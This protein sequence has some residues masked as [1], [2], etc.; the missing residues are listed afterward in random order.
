MLHSLVRH[1]ESEF[2]SD[3]I[4]RRLLLARFRVRGW[5][6]NRFAQNHPPEEPFFF[7]PLHV[8]DDSQ[9][10]VRN[11]HFFD[12]YWIIEYLSRLMPHGYKLAVKMHP[13]IDGSVPIDFLRR[14]RRLDNVTLLRADVRAT[15]VI[16]KA[17]GVIVVNS[18]VA[19]ESLL[20]GVPVLVLGHWAFGKAGITRH[21]DDLRTLGRDLDAL[22]HDKVDINDVDGVLAAFYDEM[23][24]G[25]YYQ[26][27]RNWTDIGA[28][29][30]SLMSRH[31]TTHSP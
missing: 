14:L 29:L 10:T 9:I 13:G 1:G 31:K 15:D 28:S 3:I 7:F 5:L 30:E 27:P 23:L 25:S 19:L 11:P 6:C 12:Q 26:Q 18:T 4:N 17:K 24:P 21:C 16:S 22:R 8:F 20:M 2:L